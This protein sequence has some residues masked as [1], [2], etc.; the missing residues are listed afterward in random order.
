MTDTEREMGEEENT[1]EATIEKIIKLLPAMKKFREAETLD[2]YFAQNIGGMPESFDFVERELFLDVIEQ[3]MTEL[4]DSQTAQKVRVQLEKAPIVDTGTHAGFIKDSDPSGRC[5]LN[6]NMLISAALMRAMMQDANAME[7]D[8][9][10]YHVGFYSSANSLLQAMSGGCFQ[11]GECTFPVAS[12]KVIKNGY[13]FDAP[14]ISKAYFYPMICS[15]AKFQSAIDIIDQMDRD[16]TGQAWERF[17]EEKKEEI[18]RI[19]G[20]INQENS[21]SSKKALRGIFDRNKRGVDKNEQ[22]IDS[23]QVMRDIIREGYDAMKKVFEAIQAPEDRYNYKKAEKAYNNL[24]KEKKA[25]INC[26][27][28]WAMTGHSHISPEDIDAQYQ[29]MAEIFNDQNLSLSQQALKVQTKQINQ[30]VEGTGIEH[31][32]VD[33]VEVVRHFLIKAL[34]DERTLWYRIF[35]DPE[36]FSKFQQALSGIRSGW[37]EN[38]SPFDFVEKNGGVVRIG[39]LDLQKMPKIPEEIIAALEQKE[40]I[41]SSAL[42]ITVLQSAGF[43]G[44]GGYFQAVFAEEIKEKFSNFIKKEMVDYSSQAEK[45]AQIP[46]DMMLLSYVVATDEAGQAVPF[47]HLVAMPK[48]EKEKLMRAIPSMSTEEVVQN[49]LK[50]LANYLKNKDDFFAYVQQR[51]ENNVPQETPSCRIVS[52][53]PPIYVEPTPACQIDQQAQVCNGPYNATNVYQSGVNSQAKIC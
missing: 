37:D 17:F 45:M 5:A 24:G 8:K 50:I 29:M 42:M 34:K 19:Y 1:I 39:K 12:N 13:L 32:A 14:P 23:Y 26:A 51:T 43:L 40:M 49:S 6:Q 30:L 4:Y 44:H 27:I 41:P 46:A 20:E 36:K 16:P 47:S 52:G 7:E 15:L 33:F 18:D 3:E 35:S 28:K 9:K 38:Q 11:L 21:T 53:Q 2:N 10:I 22:E 25:C 48:E 31:V